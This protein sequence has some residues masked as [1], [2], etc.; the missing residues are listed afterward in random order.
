MKIFYIFNK[1]KLEMKVFLM[2]S[3]YELFFFIFGIFNKY[4]KKLNILII[5]RF[6]FFRLGV[7]DFGDGIFGYVFLFCLECLFRF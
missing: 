2:K 6:I 1:N 3:I 5:L 4:S 7:L